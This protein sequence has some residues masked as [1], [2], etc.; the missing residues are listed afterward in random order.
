MGSYAIDAPE[1]FGLSDAPVHYHSTVCRGG[2]DS[3]IVRFGDRSSGWLERTR[4]ER[5]NSLGC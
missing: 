5:V 4:E 1:L 2:D 3:E